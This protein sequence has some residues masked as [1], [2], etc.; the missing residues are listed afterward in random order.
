MTLAVPAATLTARPMACLS[1]AT[2]AAF[3]DGFLDAARLGAVDAHLDG[4]P[5]CRGRAAARAR[6]AEVERSPSGFAA[7][8]H[9]QEA[10]AAERGADFASDDDDLDLLAGP[11]ADRLVGQILGG[12]YRVVRRIGGGGMG[13]VYEGVHTLI[14]RPVAIKVLHPQYA[15][16][17]EVLRRFRN[18]A[19]AAAVLGHPNIVAATDMGRTDDGAPFVVLELLDGTDLDR[20]I[21]RLG[22]LSPSRTVRIALQICSALS[23]A[24]GRG[25]IHRD[26]KPE[27]IFLLPGDQVKV[28]DF[29]IS[30]FTGSLLTGPSTKTGAIMGTPHYMAPEQFQDASRTDARSDI[31]ALGVILFK[32][33][34]GTTPY[35]ADSMPALMLAVVR[36]DPPDLAPLRE[37]AGGAMVA[38]VARALATAPADRYQDVAGIAAA[39]SSFD[40]TGLSGEEAAAGISTAAVTPE[41]RIVM[42]L[43]ARGL[44]DA[45]LLKDAVEREGGRIVHQAEDDLLATFGHDTLT[46]RELE[47]ALTAGLTARQAADAIAIVSGQLDTATGM[48]APASAAK[49]RT[50]CVAGVAGVIVAGESPVAPMVGMGPL[51]TGERSAIGDGA[52][53]KSAM[54]GTTTGDGT[55]GGGVLGDG[56]FALGFAARRLTR[57]S[58]E[59]TRARESAAPWSPSAGQA[60]VGRDGELA[61]LRAA[62][63]VAR[64]EGRAGLVLVTGAPG[65]GKSMLA[66]EVIRFGGETLSVFYARAEPG[67]AAPHLGLFAKLVHNRARWGAAQCGW[68][69]L[70][71]GAE[72]GTGLDLLAAILAEAGIVE[73]SATPRSARTFAPPADPARALDAQSHAPFMAELLGVGV[74]GFAPLDAARRDPRLMADRL[75]LVC[76]DYLRG[77]VER[78]PVMIVLEDIQWADSATLTLLDEL[79]YEHPTA[80][81]LVLCTARD[82]IEQHRPGVLDGHDAVEIKLRGVG[83]AAVEQLMARALGGTPPVDLVRAVHSRSGGNP[84]VAE[85]IALALQEEHGSV[86]RDDLPLPVS[87]EAAVQT[88]LDILPTDLKEIVKWLAV[89]GR[90]L[91]PREAIALGIDDASQALES[92]VR[93]QL[94]SRGPQ[95]PD[96]ERDYRFRAGLVAD[97]AYRMIAPEALP[98]MHRKVAD[99]LRANPRRARE[100][101]ASHYERA[102]R[103][104]EAAE[105]FAAAAMAAS[106]V[107][108]TDTVLRCGERALSLGTAAEHRFSIHIARADALALRGELKDQAVELEQAILAAITPAQTA[109]ALTDHAVCMQRTGHS[110]EALSIIAD[111]VAAAE[112]AGD[113]EILGRALGRQAIAQLYDGALG[114]AAALLSRAERLVQTDA[115]SLRADAAVWRAQLAGATGDLGERR[116]AYYAAVELYT[117]L[118]DPRLAAGAEANLADAYNRF[119]AYEEAIGALTSSVEACHRVGMRLMEGYAFVNLGYAHGMLGHIAEAEEAFD[120]A[121]AIAGRAGEA[122]LDLFVRLYRMRFDAAA[123]DPAVAIAESLAVANEAAIQEVHSARVLALTTASRH[124]LADGQLERAIATAREAMA[125]RDDL[126]GIEEDEAEVFLALAAALEAGGETLKAAEVRA[127]GRGRLRDLA[128]RIADPEWRD[129][130]LHDVA[131]HRALL[132]MEGEGAT[133]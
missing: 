20:E 39:L 116:N 75:R 43:V 74:E 48:P 104:H 91:C 57:T 58:F 32:S 51:G 105:L 30:K 37:V 14:G 127:Q 115:P 92:L 121:K 101:I 18:E 88:R 23:T 31:Y 83:L 52:T 110:T 3:V 131:S 46:G 87:V 68:P 122:R 113:M 98:D 118:G 21:R 72:R 128:T 95:H 106:A 49:A 4:C 19:R 56:A 130:F 64:D 69:P 13:T 129:R 107:A 50:A 45:T 12:R 132:G 44:R 34:T 103:H 99:A 79:L 41:Q 61:Q 38:I 96:G 102:G 125:L 82:E 90:E 70:D 25:I 15:Q 84:F 53:G 119:G 77:L 7:T 93:Q 2:L 22:T 124:L 1:D 100:E 24:H 65:M 111:A 85:Q 109:R 67:L 133:A 97:V 8:Q 60:P 33:L 81:L 62:V 29:G 11:S 6:S 126:G 80:P 36:G 10:A 35:Q 112:T 55:L 40:G 89:S 16:Q 114:T 66:A 28:L 42:L 78:G 59:V 120:A 47:R 94:L 73:D 71:L 27:N 108:D 86:V 123:M 5:G 9:R 26:L 54:G 63:V 117:A 76:K 17:R